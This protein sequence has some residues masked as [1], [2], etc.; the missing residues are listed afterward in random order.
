L[1]NRNQCATVPGVVSN[2]DE[3][4]SG[5][6]NPKLDGFGKRRRKKRTY[7]RRK[8]VASSQLGILQRVVG[9]VRGEMR[10]LEVLKPI[11]KKRRRGKE[12]IGEV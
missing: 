7:R 8:T 9:A 6:F 5:P 3:G 4:G 2:R 12:K 10:C 11:N 1:K